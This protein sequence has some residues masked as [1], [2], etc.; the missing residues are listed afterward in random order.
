MSLLS[1]AFRNV[2]IFPKISRNGQK[3][4]AKKMFAQGLPHTDGRGRKPKEKKLLRTNDWYAF[5][6]VF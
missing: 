6:T 3:E 4:F 1:E 2:S 5:M